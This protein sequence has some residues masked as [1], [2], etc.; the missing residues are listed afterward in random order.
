[1]FFLI[2]LRPQ[3]QFQAFAKK[4]DSYY[5]LACEIR[6][7][8]KDSNWWSSSNYFEP[9][10]FSINHISGCHCK[11]AYD[12]F[13]RNRKCYVQCATVKMAVPFNVVGY[14]HQEQGLPVCRRHPSQQTKERGNESCIV[15][16]VVVVLKR[17]RRRSTMSVIPSVHQWSN[18]I[19]NVLWNWFVFFCLVKRE[20][21]HQNNKLNRC[22]FFEKPCVYVVVFCSKRRTHSFTKWKWLAK[23]QQ[24]RLN[25]WG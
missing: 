23:T 5:C 4:H 17:V 8:V 20:N 19:S 25:L 12:F 21:Y 9:I 6:S 22:F 18:H 1:M 15:A 11:S 7:F 24:D 2:L 16:F 10:S 13:T 3:F 14:Y